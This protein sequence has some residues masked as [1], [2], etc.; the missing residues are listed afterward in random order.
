LEKWTELIDAALSLGAQKASL[1]PVEAISF[2]PTFR[3][4]CIQN[5]CGMYGRCW[6]CPPDVGQVD[7]LISSAR[8]YLCALVFQT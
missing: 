7:E 6:M 3:N 2:E 8:Q 1:I 5:Y 4:A